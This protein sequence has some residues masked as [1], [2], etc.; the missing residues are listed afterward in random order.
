MTRHFPRLF[1]WHVARHARR[2]K[3]LAALNVLSVALGVSVYLAIQIANHSANQAFSASIDLVAGKANLEVRSPGGGF[4]ETLLPKLSNVPGVKAATP[5]VEGY[6]TLPAYPGE[7]LQILGVDMFTNLP[8]ATFAIGGQAPA[9]ALNLNLDAWLGDP[10]GIAITD[11]FAKTHALKVGDTMR[12]QVNGKEAP[13]TVRFLIRLADTVAGR[14]NS[15]VAAMDIGWAQEFLGK[16]GKLSSIQILLDQPRDT[17]PMA[18]ALGKLAPADVTIAA[19]G[20]RSG[21]VQRMLS[22]FE[23]NLGALSLVALLVGM[24]LIYN[25]IAASVVRRR[26]E[27]GILRAIGV[28]RLGGA[29]AVHGGGAAVRI[30]RR[31]AGDRRRRVD[32][33]VLLRPGNRQGHQ[34]AL[35]AR[36]R[37]SLFAVAAAAGQR[38]LFRVWAP[39]SRRRGCRRG[40]ARARTRSRR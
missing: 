33:A 16:R 35:H 8:F 5:L 14:G 9:E 29:G 11:E 12:L 39:C 18:A 31:A 2:H 36:Q 10:R 28:T 30:H 22:S 1:L 24:F 15:R 4:D 6:A 19:P 25:T 13:L 23:L 3:L 40:K 17:E 7:Y 32:G 21:Q 38:V 34:H 26:V 20:Q 27:T 37:G